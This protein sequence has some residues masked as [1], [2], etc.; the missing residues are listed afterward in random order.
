MAPDSV[1]VRQQDPDEINELVEALQAG[2]SG[3]K[4]SK[5]MFSCRK[6][7]YDIEG[8]SHKVDSWKFQ[9]YAYKS[10]KMELPTYARGLFTWTDPKSGNSRIAVRGY[11]KFFNT[12][13]VQ[14]TKW[15]WIEKHTRGPYE[16]TLK[17]NGCIIFISG[18]ED[19]TLLV[20]SKHSTGSRGDASKS[21][22]SVGEAWVER[23]VGTKGRTKDELAR[24]LYKGNITLVAELCDDSFEEHILAYADDRAGL[25]VHGINLNLPVFATYPMDKVE[26][27]AED[28]GF[29]KVKHF[30]KD[31][32]EDLRKFLE[33][34]AESG[35][36]EGEAVEGFVVRCKSRFGP[37][38][39]YW[40]DWFFKY[41]FDEPYLLY[42]QW[43]ECTKAMIS[44]KVPRI[45]KQKALTEQY[46]KF[47]K[48]YFIK[49]PEAKT[50]YNS[51]HGIIKLRDLF[52]AEQGL[53]GA[54]IIQR[55]AE[56]EASA[57]RKF[58]LV[59]VA[60][61][62]CGKTTV[63]YALTNLF[64][65]GHRQNDNIPS[66]KGPKA[67]KFADFCSADLIHHPAV[68]ADRNN[69]QKR[70]RE[71]LINDISDHV[72]EARF[73]ALHYV[74]YD[75][76]DDEA[77]HDR[78]R[79]A[80]R[81]RVFA[82]GDN[83]QTINASSD[84]QSKIIGIMEGFMER[85][86]PID[87]EEKPDNAFDLV[88]DID[89]VADS[90]QNLETIVKELH[91]HYPKLVPEIPSPE[92]LDNAIRAAFEEYRPDIKHTIGS[93]GPVV[94]KKLKNQQPQQRQSKASF[95]FFSLDVP[96]SI[97]NPILEETFAANP[98]SR[99]FFDS[100]KSSDRVQN[101]FHVTLIHQASSK[102]QPQLWEKYNNLEKP[103]VP[104]EKKVD[105][106]VTFK[107]VSWDD[108]V[109]AIEVELPTGWE[110]AN[111]IAHI[112]IGT[113]DPSVKPKEAN[114]MLQKKEKDSVEIK[115][116]ETVVAGQFAA[117]S[118][119]R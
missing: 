84:D 67:R 48:Q 76:F 71:Q 91:K 89:P 34:T 106:P 107:R 55:S 117:V 40:H 51:N 4:K 109:M 25:Y 101:K 20:C 53:H 78:I 111:K 118:S 74:H 87:R 90:R 83:H 33:T 23:M 85:F 41:K 115:T 12:G 46:L 73:I 47:A 19:G 50:Q 18:L 10:T 119:R 59:P 32:V 38:D 49:N 58:V 96:A 82:R 52:L 75:D 81:E 57:D 72:P 30:L 93:R 56:E 86:Q 43:R 114:D 35:A 102:L 36:W 98:R 3:P 39:P 105:I 95:E 108:R 113:K 64:N 116:S 21:H 24:T 65:W 99:A 63:A 62:G 37:D 112:T 26:K 104:K 27:F 61:I 66:G 54:D 100:L 70:E 6:T 80:T 28:W 92:K 44:G 79:K 5:S 94:Q 77:L 16:I 68:I 31:N 1:L 13:E 8:T 103:D 45:R 7:S 29:K 88:I 14:R 11:D 2:S 69:H 42:R 60:S 110:S 22:A 9:E 17:E 97:I 15:E